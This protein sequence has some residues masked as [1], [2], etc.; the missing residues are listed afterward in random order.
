M[1]KLIRNDPPAAKKDAV[2]GCRMA[3]KKQTLERDG[4]LIGGAPK[5]AALA[6]VNIGR[7]G[8]PPREPKC[9]Q[10]ADQPVPKSVGNACGD[11]IPNGLQHPL[12]QKI[13]AIRQMRRP[14]RRAMRADG[15]RS[16]YGLFQFKAHTPI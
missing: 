13:H 9:G 12:N 8:A 3:E 16:D 14:I 2:R 7:D 1:E 15:V 6:L 5:L 10:S 4:T 11:E